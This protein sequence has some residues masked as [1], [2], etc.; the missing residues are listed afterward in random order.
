MTEKN[1][2]MVL[3]AV[4]SDLMKRLPR[5]QSG[6]GDA[7]LITLFGSRLELVLFGVDGDDPAYEIALFLPDARHARKTLLLH[8]DGTASEDTAPIAP[9]HLTDHEP[10]FS[11]ATPTAIALEVADRLADLGLI[12]PLPIVLS[13]D[14]ARAFVAALAE[15]GEPSERLRAAA[16]RYKDRFAVNN[17]AQ[18]DP[19]PPVFH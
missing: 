19:E 1:D 16:Q 12:A 8:Q 10:D 3:A 14:G 17:D 18:E 5:G 13:E 4:Y 9:D 15:P 7:T 2:P 6:S 11:N